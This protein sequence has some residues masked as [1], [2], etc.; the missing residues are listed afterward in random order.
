MH[1]STLHRVVQ[2]TARTSGLLFAA[3]QTASALNRSAIHRAASR[4]AHP[5][6]LAFMTA[7]AIHFTVVARYAVA[8]G[9]RRLFPGGRNLDDVGGWRTV[10]GIYTAFAAL[11]VVGT[12]AITADP[13]QP[14]H[15]V[16]GLTATGLIAAMFVSTY[17]RQLP[18]SRWFAAP[19]INIGAATVAN[20][21]AS[22]VTS[23]QRTTG[24]HGR[25][26]TPRPA[27]ER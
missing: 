8:T 3:A 2:L 17:L 18:R 6:Y 5:L 26:A 1:T 7:H 21:V 13:N 24:T 9:G 19:A 25:P 10:F 4:A 15:R 16:T 12:T 22:V 11:A 14:R 27:T 20:I 23:H